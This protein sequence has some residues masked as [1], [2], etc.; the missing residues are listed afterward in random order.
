MIYL[1]YALLIVLGIALVIVVVPPIRRFVIMGPL[2]RAIAPGLPR[3]SATEQE[4]LDAGT[5]WWDAQLF[6]GNPDLG[7]LLGTDPHGAVLMLLESNH[8]DPADS[9]P[10]M[11]NWVWNE[12][13]TSNPDEALSF[14]DGLFDY[15]SEER[16]ST[17]SELYYLLSKDGAKRG[18]IMK[19]PDETVRPHW[20]PFIRVAS[21][22][23]GC[24]AFSSGRLRAYG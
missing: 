8:G 5:V 22:V 4:A 15:D 24:S 16:D 2:Y 13:W 23:S 17:I 9:K 6:T 7:V 3:I 1:L 21:R 14:Y 11:D 18:G 20:V 19:L 12:L 10:E